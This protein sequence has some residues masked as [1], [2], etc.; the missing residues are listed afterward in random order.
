MQNEHPEQH[1]LSVE[2]LP[3]DHS[4][5]LHKF[6]LTQPQIH[7]RADQFSPCC[8]SSILKPMCCIFKKNNG[9]IFIYRFS[10]PKVVCNLFL[11]PYHVFQIVFLCFSYLHLISLLLFVVFADYTLW[12]WIF[13]CIHNVHLWAPNNPESISP[14]RCHKGLRW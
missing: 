2:R 7:L 3:S 13:G 14:G 8:V 10:Y 1:H 12:Q 11:M 4:P 6:T 5:A 9:S